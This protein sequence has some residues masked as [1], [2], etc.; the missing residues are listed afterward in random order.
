MMRH[1]TTL[2]HPVCPLALAL[3]CPSVTKGTRPSAPF[4]T[5]TVHRAELVAV[6]DAL[7]AVERV[8]EDS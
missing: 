2:T 4:V 5:Q 1:Y 8:R 7:G 3:V 6:A